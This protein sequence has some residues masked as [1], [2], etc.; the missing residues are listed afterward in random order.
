MTSKNSDLAPSPVNRRRYLPRFRVAL[1]V[2]VSLALIPRLLTRKT[3]AKR[4]HEPASTALP[5]GRAALERQASIQAV[6][7]ALRERLSI[8]NVVVVSLVRS[9]ARAFVR[10]KTSRPAVSPSVL[11]LH[12]VHLFKKDSDFQLPSAML[13][14]ATP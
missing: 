3:L 5:K 8:P 4:A 7:D 11:R 12:L 1:L 2:G 9:C 6:T 10:A 14:N 13:K